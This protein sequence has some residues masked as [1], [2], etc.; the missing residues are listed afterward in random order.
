[1]IRKFLYSGLAVL[2][3]ALGACLPA[4]AAIG[5]PFV[6]SK[7]DAG[8]AVAANTSRSFTLTC[9]GVSVGDFVE[10]S[11]AADVILLQVSG[12]VSA[13]NTITVLISN[14]SAGSITSPNT[15]YYVIVW[16]KYISP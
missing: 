13:A 2:V 9:P 4:Q 10:V 1:M 12:Y 15:T 5:I 11:A 7:A 6:C 14:V 3:L 8:A 16:R